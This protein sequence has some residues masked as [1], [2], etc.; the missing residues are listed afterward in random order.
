MRRTLATS[1]ALVGAFTLSACASESNGPKS[2]D[3]LISI[4]EK[5]GYDCDAPTP[6]ESGSE[7]AW[8]GDVSVQYFDDSKQESESFAGTQKVF[9]GTPV[10]VDMIRGEKWQISSSVRAGK[11]AISKLADDMD[12]KVTTING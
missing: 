1:I 9:E 11:A 2:M 5:A 10:T 6:Q 3:E 7:A 4:V 8:C 12:M